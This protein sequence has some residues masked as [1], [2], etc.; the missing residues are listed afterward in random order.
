MNGGKVKSGTDEKTYVISG[1]PLKS[2]TKHTLAFE[3]RYDNNPGANLIRSEFKS[4]LLFSNFVY[5]L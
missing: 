5:N 3:A 1:D 2:G 4:I